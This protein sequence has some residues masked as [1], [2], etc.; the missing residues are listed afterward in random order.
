MQFATAECDALC[1]GG[2]D[3]IRRPFGLTGQVGRAVVRM[4]IVASWIETV[5]GL[6]AKASPGVDRIIRRRAGLSAPFIVRIW[7]HCI[8]PD[9]NIRRSR[10]LIGRLPQWTAR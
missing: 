5:G 1:G 10:S 2:G 9:V 4:R 3:G 7:R 8:A 6:C